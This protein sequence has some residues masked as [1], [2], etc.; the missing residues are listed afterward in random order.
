MIGGTPQ[1]QAKLD[2]AKRLRMRQH[3]RRNT[4]ANL[5]RGARGGRRR[6]SFHGG[7][8]AGRILRMDAKTGAQTIAASGLNQPG[9]MAFD[10]SGNLYA[11][12]QG[13]SRI[14]AFAQAGAAAK[15]ITISPASGAFGNA[16]TG[17]RLQLSNSH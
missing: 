11:A 6:K 15:R 4:D 1:V 13:M 14:V 2:A 5:P 3:G 8:T 9:A 12:E 7:A 16:P 17:A 10:A